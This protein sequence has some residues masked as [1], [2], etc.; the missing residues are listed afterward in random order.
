MLFIHADGGTDHH[1]TYVFVQ[2]SLVLPALEGGPRLP[3]CQ[4]NCTISL[5]AKPIGESYVS[6]EFG[7]VGLAREKMPEELEK[8][9]AKCNRNYERLQKER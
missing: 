9:I 7:V 2:L 4:S 5:A 3:L 6:I 8:E 1:L